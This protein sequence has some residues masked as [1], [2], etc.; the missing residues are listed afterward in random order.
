MALRIAVPIYDMC[1]PYTYPCLLNLSVIDRKLCE[2]PGIAAEIMADAIASARLTYQLI[3][4]ETPDW[5]TIIGIDPGIVSIIFRINASVEYMKKFVL[6][7]KNLIFHYLMK[8][9]K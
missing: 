6:Y 4:T 5:G 2:F 1:R 7:L 8:I 3:P 9:Y